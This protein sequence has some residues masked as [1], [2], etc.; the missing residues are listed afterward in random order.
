MFDANELNMTGR[1]KV[2]LP[3]SLRYILRLQF[4]ILAGVSTPYTQPSHHHHIF[5]SLTSRNHKLLT[6][7]HAA[8]KLLL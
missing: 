2:A 6:F 5:Y 3:T 4:V 7:R 8:Y 1:T